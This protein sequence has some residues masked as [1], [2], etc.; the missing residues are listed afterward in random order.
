MNTVRKELKRLK[1]T[2]GNS[3]VTMTRLVWVCNINAA[4]FTLRLL[5]VK[6]LVISGGRSRPGGQGRE[7]LLCRYF[8][9]I[10]S[11]TSLSIDA[12]PIKLTE[13]LPK[14][15]IFTPNICASVMPTVYRFLPLSFL[16]LAEQ[17][18]WTIQSQL[19]LLQHSHSGTLDRR[20]IFYRKSG[21]RRSWWRV[22]QIKKFKNPN[23]S[24]CKQGRNSLWS[25][26]LRV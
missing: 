10:A 8:P 22:K 16:D 14:N 24:S 18:R 5:D 9:V 1:H 23:K 11:S 13:H 4:L 26:I 12:Q 2:V 15:H 19:P 6:G 17:H 21:V 25:E 20:F 3:M 7:K